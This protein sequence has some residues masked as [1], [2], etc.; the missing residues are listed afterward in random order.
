MLQTAQLLPHVKA[1]GVLF[2]P[3]Y[4][5]KDWHKEERLTVSAQT[6]QTTVGGYK[7]D[8]HQLGGEEFRILLGEQL[9]RGQGDAC[10]PL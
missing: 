3:S 6:Y 5:Y 9:W 8:K 4:A 7:G 1:R 2:V 10:Q